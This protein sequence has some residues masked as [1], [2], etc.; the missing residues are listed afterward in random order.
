MAAEDRWLASKGWTGKM[1]ASDVKLC[2]G[3]AVLDMLTLE[4]ALALVQ[5]KQSARGEL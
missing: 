2:G 4:Q 1:S 5:Q 3:S